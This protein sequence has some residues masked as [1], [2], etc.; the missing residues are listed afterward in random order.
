VKIII[1]ESQ[2]NAI[3]NEGRL[4]DFG[5]LEWLR[6]H[7]VEMTDKE[8]EYFSRHKVLYWDGKE[9]LKLVRKAKAKDSEDGEVFFSYTHR[10]WCSC[11]STQK[12]TAVKQAKFIKTTS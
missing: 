6:K 4:K 1:T 11:P 2:L 8:K 10:A 5:G 7:Q 3:V 9:G 12:A